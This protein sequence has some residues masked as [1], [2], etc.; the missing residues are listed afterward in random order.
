MSELN[1]CDSTRSVSEKVSDTVRL[2]RRFLGRGAAAAPFL[3]TLASQPALGATCFTPSRSL[4]KNTSVSQ[5]GKEGECTGSASPEDYKALQANH[6]SRGRGPWPNGLSPKD[7][8]H[9]IFAMGSNEGVTKFTKPGKKQM[10]SQTFGEVLNQ[11]SGLNIHA[12]LIAA[13]FNK[14][15]VL[16]SSIP[17]NVIT[18]TGIL[19]MWS[20]YAKK[21]YYEPFAGVKWYGEEIKNYLLS[22]GIVR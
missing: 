5:Q 8:F 15:S 6:N 10:V 21:G 13:Y 14:R 18:T 7:S 3:I 9:A 11:V 12:Y 4:S 16:S 20:E 19:N 2:R 1:K 22:N 17:D